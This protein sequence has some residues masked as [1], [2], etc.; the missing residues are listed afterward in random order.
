MME[1]K[2]RQS[3]KLCILSYIKNLRQTTTNCPYSQCVNSCFLAGFVV[4]QKL[5][6]VKAFNCPF[7]L[8]LVSSSF[9]LSSDQLKSFEFH[10]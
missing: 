2:E 10:H 1:G 9:L 5:D 3:E 6:I 4:K 8:P 7:S